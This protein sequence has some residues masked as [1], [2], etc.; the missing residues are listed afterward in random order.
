MGVQSGGS[1]TRTGYLSD[2]RFVVLD[3]E[4]EF[5]IFADAEVVAV[6]LP[7]QSEVRLNEHVWRLRLP[8][9]DDAARRV[10][11]G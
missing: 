2:G 1:K 7:D 6:D 9:L 10:L 5:C 3:M 11:I 8:E 4:E